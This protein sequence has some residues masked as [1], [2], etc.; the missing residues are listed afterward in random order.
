MS[1]LKDVSMIFSATEKLKPMQMS[2]RIILQNEQYIWYYAELN[3]LNQS[4]RI[5]YKNIMGGTKNCPE[6]LQRMIGMMYLVL[7]P[8]LHWMLQR[9]FK[10]F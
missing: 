8:C 7:L 5:K 4:S 10:R 9:N 2:W 1:K 3:G 6:T